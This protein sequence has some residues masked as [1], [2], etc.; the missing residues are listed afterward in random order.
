MCRFKNSLD[1]TKE[2]INKIK[3]RAEEIIQT[4]LK[5]EVHEKY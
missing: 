1:Q 4:I 3:Q 5:E 2:R